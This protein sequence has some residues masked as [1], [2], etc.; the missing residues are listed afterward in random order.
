MTTPQNAGWRSRIEATYKAGD[1]EEIIDIW[2]YRPIGYALAVGAHKIDVSPN[3]ISVIGMLVGMLGGHFFFYDNI[4]LNCLGILCWMA[5][6][7]LDGADGQLARMSN[8]RSKTGRVLDGLSD[9]FKFLSVYVHI[10]A[11]I[12]VATGSWWV[13]LVG[14]L[15]MWSHSAQSA[16]ADYYRN[17]YI[18]FVYDPTKG[19]LDQ[20]ERIVEEYRSFSWRKNFWKKFLWFFYIPYTNTQEKLSGTVEELREAAL[21]RFGHEIPDEVKEEYRRRNKPNLMWL[22]S[23]TTNT[24]MLILYASLFIGN[25]WIYLIADLT[26]FNGVLLVLRARQHRIN[27]EMM[28]RVKRAASVE[29]ESG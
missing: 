4:Y 11:R 3:T 22:N 19:E 8:R 21:K 16:F 23:L 24:R 15:A 12:F 14:F 9:S 7:A 17:L 1:V 28:E 18:F 10:M 2:F 13:F 27:E 5:G 26:W 29:A 20:S 25:L 6:Q